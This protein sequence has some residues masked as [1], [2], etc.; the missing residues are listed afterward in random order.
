MGNPK[1]NKDVNK[2]A[3]G[4]ANT[5]NQQQGGLQNSI[6]GG[7][8]GSQ[9]RSNQVFDAAFGGYQGLLGGLQGGAGS[10][11]GGGGGGG[12]KFFDQARN[13]IMGM[14]APQLSNPWAGQLGADIRARGDS[15]LPG[16]YDRIKQEQGRLQNIQGGY[17]PGYT[18]Q[19]SKL[20]RDQSQSAQAGQLNRE[21]ELG[22]KQAD[23]QRQNEM[24]QASFAAQKASMLAGLAGQQARGAAGARAAGAA[25]DQ[26]NFRNQMSVLNA[27]GGLRGQTPGEVNM[28][29]GAGLNNVQNRGI[30]NQGVGQLMQYNQPQ[31]PAWQKALGAAGQVAGA[32]FGMPF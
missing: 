25:S 9:G 4:N 3:F 15:I 26:E 23:I 24:A 19:M 27:M 10:G 11:G 12:G 20:A 18:A 14:S 30:A 1:P 28:Y 31:V 5:F 16:F 17:N 13:D 21:V 29:L 2:L 32:A 6:M 8:D 22:Q 7:L